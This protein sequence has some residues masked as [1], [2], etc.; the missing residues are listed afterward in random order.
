MHVT[1]FCKHKWHFI[2]VLFFPGLVSCLLPITLQWW[3]LTRYCPR[4]DPA[5]PSWAPHSHGSAS[6]SCTALLYTRHPALGCWEV[7]LRPG[8]SGVRPPVARPLRTGVKCSNTPLG[9]AKISLNKACQPHSKAGSTPQ[10]GL[11]LSIKVNIHQ[12][13]HSPFSQLCTQKKK[14]GEEQKQFHLVPSV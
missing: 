3:W 7:K 6:N 13:P 5:A 11:C 1:T 9:L 8:E 14:E 2:Y 12:P 10:F 4:P